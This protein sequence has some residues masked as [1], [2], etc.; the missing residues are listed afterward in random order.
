[1]KTVHF[2]RSKVWFIFAALVI[3]AAYMLVFQPEQIVDPS[4]KDIASRSLVKQTVSE[5][6][7]SYTPTPA[8]Y[9]DDTSST[10]VTTKPSVVQS[11]PAAPQSTNSV[12]VTP[13]P[14]VSSDKDYT[15]SGTDPNANYFD[16]WG[17]E[18]DYQGNLISV[19]NC[20][21]ADI[22]PLSGPNPYCTSN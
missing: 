7:A 16:Q 8:V 17:N 6:P 21:P 1:M 13:A 15:S 18:F 12:A 10:P 22:S 20:D 2:I 9:N 3:L 4:F 19:G 5:K 14:A 11:T